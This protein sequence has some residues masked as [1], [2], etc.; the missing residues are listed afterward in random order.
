[1]KFPVKIIV[2]LMVFYVLNGLK[3]YKDVSKKEETKHAFIQKIENNA[4]VKKISTENKKVLNQLNLKIETKTE[5]TDLE[6]ER[7]K[8][9]N[10][11]CIVN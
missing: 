1:M 6:F 3:F 9:E 4:A 8:K 10:D 2:L 5:K 7:I 11:V